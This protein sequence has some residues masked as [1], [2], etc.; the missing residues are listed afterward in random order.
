MSTFKS[1]MQRPSAAKLWQH[2]AAIV[3]PS[4]PFW[5]SRSM[6]E[7]VQATSYF[8]ASASISSLSIS[9]IRTPVRKIKCS[10]EY[11]FA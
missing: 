4:F 2:P 6:P 1:V 10:R 11:L 8:A 5:A 3:L 9:S 7:E